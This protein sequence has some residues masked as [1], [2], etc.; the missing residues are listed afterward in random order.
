L[1]K[2]VN[3]LAAE[4]IN[5]LKGV[6]VLDRQAH[7]E[8]GPGRGAEPPLASEYRETVVGATVTM[9]GWLSVFIECVESPFVLR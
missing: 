9:T 8:L 5:E 7:E 1:T 2:S 3:D 6:L 4:E